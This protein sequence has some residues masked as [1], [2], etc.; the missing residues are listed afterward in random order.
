MKY[1][2]TTAVILLGLLSG[3][4]YA[5]DMHGAGHHDHAKGQHAAMSESETTLTDGVI[6]AVDHN[7]GTITVEHGPIKSLGMPAM[8]MPYHVKDRAMLKTFKPGDRIKM[9]V[10]KT[11]DMYTIMTMQ[12]AH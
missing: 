7:A 2:P 5:G 4:A 10:D 6:R 11:G 3:A 8:T 9:S 1:Q 12:Q